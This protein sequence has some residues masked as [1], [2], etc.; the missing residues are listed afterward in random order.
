MMARIN[1]MGRG[2]KKFASEAIREMLPAQGS[3]LHSS[4]FKARET[5]FLKKHSSLKSNYQTQKSYVDDSDYRH[6]RHFST[7]LSAMAGFPTR[8]FIW[9][10]SNANEKDKFGY[11]VLQNMAA[12][13][14]KN[15]ASRLQRAVSRWNIVPILYGT[16][17][18]LLAP[19]K[20][21]INV[22][23][24]GT[25]FLPNF[26]FK[27][28]L[29]L[30]RRSARTIFHA[31]HHPKYSRGKKFFKI[32][33]SVIGF[34]IA[35]LVMVAAKG[36]EFFGMAFTSP[37]MAAMRF[38]ELAQSPKKRGDNFLTWV[39]RGLGV[40]S[41]VVSLAEY[42]ALAVVVVPFSLV[43]GSAF[44]PGKLGILFDN[45]LMGVLNVSQWLA[46]VLAPIGK[47]ISATIGFIFP[48]FGFGMSN[49]VIGACAIAGATTVSAGSLVQY[50]K[51]LDSDRYHRPA[52]ETFLRKK[53]TSPKSSPQPTPMTERIVVH[54]RASSLTTLGTPRSENSV[55]PP[56]PKRAQTPLSHHVRSAS[57]TAALQ[58]RMVESEEGS[59]K[60]E[61]SSPD[62]K[63]KKI[64]LLKGH[65]SAMRPPASP[66]PKPKQTGKSGVDIS[67]I[68]LPSTPS[69]P[70][71]PTTLGVK[72]DTSVRKKRKF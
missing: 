22:L 50:A 69:A 40:V 25:E 28:S 41:A 60:S 64:A 36:V 34:G 13:P 10:K 2:V 62:E 5:S 65:G 67:A 63:S 29:D 30:V 51:G 4:A 59:K 70:S 9:D 16:W 54:R 47:V 18:I 12:L 45:M 43:M 44:L 56:T 42:V 57:S 19:I 49:A 53:T 52:L 38:F 32:A 37:R 71:S 11:N 33:P 14:E 7:L 17:N 31:Y 66:P 15:S 35:F 48:S 24:L 61:K 72:Q 23:R 8:N 68:W 21:S 27:L 46:P 1:R 26:T 39:Y 58:A 55:P 20:F 3:G 6:S